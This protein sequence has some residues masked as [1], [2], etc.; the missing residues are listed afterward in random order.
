MNRKQSQDPHFALPEFDVPQRESPGAAQITYEEAV[1]AFEE[2][3][4][5]LKLHEQPRRPEEPPP[6]ER[7]EM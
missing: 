2:M 7:F 6:T 3:A 5:A 4:T 1:R